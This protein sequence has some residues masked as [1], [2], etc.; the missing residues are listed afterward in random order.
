MP[1]D[2]MILWHRRPCCGRFIGPLFTD[3]ARVSEKA[4]TIL[5]ADEYCADQG[6]LKPHASHLPMGPYVAGTGAGS[7]REDT[8]NWRAMMHQVISWTKICR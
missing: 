1:S 6:G 3:W 8:T 7:I 4:K 2:F 5:T